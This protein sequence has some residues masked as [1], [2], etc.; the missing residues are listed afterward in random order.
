VYPVAVDRWIVRIDSNGTVIRRRRSPRHGSL[1]DLAAELVSFPSLLAHPA[2]EIE[3]LLI[4]E[5][6]ARCHVQGRCWRRAGWTTI[7]RRLIDVRDRVVFDTG[8]DLAV[9]LPDGLP[10]TFTTSDLAAAIHRPRRVAQQLAYCLA[11][12]GAL[13]GVGKRGHSVLYR[14]ASSPSA[15]SRP[16]RLHP[17]ALT[18]GDG[19][20]RPRDQGGSGL[21][22]R[23]CHRVTHATID[24]RIRGGVGPADR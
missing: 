20:R 21:V 3:V 16:H 12:V 17:T 2:F 14:V 10:D 13:E 18:A 15:S 19:V 7:E 6:E 23:P 24:R 22:R 5:E 8:A 1:A 4:E 9:L 11:K